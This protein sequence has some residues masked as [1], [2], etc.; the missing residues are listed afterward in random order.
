MLTREEGEVEGIKVI[1]SKGDEG[2]VLGS[3]S[4]LDLESGIAIPSA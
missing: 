4:V 2:N 3:R 1:A